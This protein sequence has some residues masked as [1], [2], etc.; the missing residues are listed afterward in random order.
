MWCNPTASGAWPAGRRWEVVLVGVAHEQAAVWP[1]TKQVQGRAR[2][3]T[4]AYTT[5]YANYCMYFLDRE[6][7]RV[8]EGLWLRPVPAGVGL[9][10]HE[11]A[12]RE[13]AR[14]GI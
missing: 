13:L 5:V 9:N 1:D 11:W 8:P 12:Q 10:G 6:E 2:H 4:S 7:G 3:C 14:Q